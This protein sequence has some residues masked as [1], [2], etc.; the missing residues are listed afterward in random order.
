LRSQ[1]ELIIIDTTPLCGDKGSLLKIQFENHSNIQSF[2]DKIYNLLSSGFVP[3]FTYGKRWV[4]RDDDTGEK[5]FDIGRNTNYATA[6]R[7]GSTYGD[8]YDLSL[9]EGGI[10]PGMHLS[11]IRINE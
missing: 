11:T 10:K 9:E 4:L 3:I 7:T 6:Y 8:R 5:F 1:K 2:L